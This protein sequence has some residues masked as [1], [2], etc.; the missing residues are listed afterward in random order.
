MR[1]VP[2]GGGSR[3]SQ[4]IQRTL[5]ARLDAVYPLPSF[6]D[7]S[8]ASR[9]AARRFW[10]ER[11]WSEFA[12]IPALS[13][14][15]LGLVSE[16]APF[17]EVAGITG[18]LQ[19]EA[20]HTALS[21]QVAEAF[22][23]Y[24][25]EIPEHLAFDPYPLAEPSRHGL[26]AWLVVGGCVAETLSRS[27][28]AAR[29]KHTRPPELREI[30]GRTLRDENL[31]VA[32]AWAAATRAVKRLPEARRKE[33]ARLAGPTVEAASRTLCTAGL[34]G[35]GKGIERRLR[36]RVADAG[37]GACPPD[38]EDAAVKLA[39]ERTVIPGLIRL[40]ILAA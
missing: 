30:L 7:V 22:G 24:V 26:A 40:G 5:G 13:Q 27:L 23:G 38:E 14:V 29:L 31:H 25:E 8:K 2:L 10:S 21:M 36:Q 11:A 32:F 18:I 35:V 6:K 19:D 9:E 33:L 3:E 12:A 17:S 28:I 39:L 20:L 4:V 37:L 34:T 1:R 16:R 15:S